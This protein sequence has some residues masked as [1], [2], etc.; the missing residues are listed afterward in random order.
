MNETKKNAPINGVAAKPTTVT[1]PG[2]LLDMQIVC[3]QVFLLN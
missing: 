2:N 3:F 1:T